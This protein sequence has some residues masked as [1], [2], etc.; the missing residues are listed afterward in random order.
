MLPAPTFALNPALDRS[1]IATALAERSRV[2]I[3]DV[4][5]DDSAQSILRLLEQTD[6]TLSWQ[7]LGGQ[8]SALRETAPNFA[9]VKVAIEK[10]T[11]RAVPDHKR[12]TYLCRDHVL[13]PREGVEPGSPYGLLFEALCQPAFLEFIRA[14]TSDPTIVRMSAR[15]TLYEPGNFLTFHN[16]GG[17]E[18]RR[19]AFVL[20]LCAVEWRPDWGGYLMF[21]NKDGNVVDGFKPRFNTLNLFRVPQWHAIPM[22][23][24]SAPRARYA[25]SGWFFDR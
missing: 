16:D 9:A 18:G 2:Q 1:N 22:V 19:F 4:L 5:T 12:L 13:A 6:W 15:A 7:V 20:N 25:I 3:R 11:A 21:Y 23:A 24:P 17:E 10:L 14:V 8:I